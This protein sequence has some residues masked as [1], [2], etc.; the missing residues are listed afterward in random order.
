MAVAIKA[1]KD[2]LKSEENKFEKIYIIITKLKILNKEFKFF[3]YFDAKNGITYSK[4]PILE[5]FSTIYFNS[6]L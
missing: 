5:N 3:L 1:K 2:I 4:A 6:I